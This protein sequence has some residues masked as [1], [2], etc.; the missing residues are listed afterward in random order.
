VV[1][2]FV[3]KELSKEERVEDFISGRD[4][5]DETTVIPTIL[6]IENAWR[7]MELEVSGTFHEGAD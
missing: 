7:E 1:G 2:I 4:P 3:C 6:E 5:G